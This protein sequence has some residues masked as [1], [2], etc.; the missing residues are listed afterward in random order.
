MPFPQQ[1]RR[2][3]TEVGVESLPSGQSG[4][5]GILNAEGWVYIGQAHDLRASLMRHVLKESA[6]SVCIHINQPTG[7]VAELVPVPKLA[8]REAALI[9]EF[10]PRCNQFP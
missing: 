3:F 1:A 9:R 2:L 6:E 5:Y 4:V 7:W 8:D 10:R